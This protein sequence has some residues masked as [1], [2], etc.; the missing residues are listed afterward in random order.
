MITKAME[1]KYLDRRGVECPFCESSDIEGQEINI[2]GGGAWQEVSCN[3]C[4]KSWNDL[5]ELTGI[6]E[7]EE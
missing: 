7:I 6:E 3:T 1:K 2:D 5:Y 4:G